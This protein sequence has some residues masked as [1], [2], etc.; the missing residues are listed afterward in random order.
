MRCPYAQATMVHSPMP[1]CTTSTQ[2]GSIFVCT[3]CLGWDVHLAMARQADCLDKC[4]R[5]I[6]RLL[7]LLR[8]GLT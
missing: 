4:Y 1:L 8:A 7:A 2:Y 3:P 6:T 5:D